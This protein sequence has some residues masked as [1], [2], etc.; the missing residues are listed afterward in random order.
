MNRD[1]PL[2]EA[3]A[4][5]VLGHVSSLWGFAVELHGVDQADEERYCHAVAA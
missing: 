5:A 4:K 2:A 3:D 1:V